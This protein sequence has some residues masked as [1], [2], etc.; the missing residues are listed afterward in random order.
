MYRLNHTSELRR[1]TAYNINLTLRHY[2]VHGCTRCGDYYRLMAASIF[3]EICRRPTLQPLVVTFSP[4]SI[5]TIY[6]C[7][8]AAAFGTAVHS[9]N[10]TDEAYTS[11]SLFHSPHHAYPTDIVTF[12]LGNQKSILLRAKAGVAGAV[13]VPNMACLLWGAQTSPPVLCN[14]RLPSCQRSLE[15]HSSGAWEHS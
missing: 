8:S 14:F 13:Q 7:G 1:R 6:L 2:F 10:K 15:L 5:A 12:G 9:R 11:C 4:R 3:L